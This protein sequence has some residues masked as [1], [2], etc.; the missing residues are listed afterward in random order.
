[1]PRLFTALEIPDAVAEALARYQCGLRGA[2]WIER[3]DLHVTLRFL[4]DVDEEVAEAVHAGLV[5]AR[6]RAPVDVTITGLDAFGGEALL[7]APDAG[8][9]LGRPPHDLDRAEPGG[10]EQHDLGAPDVLLGGVAVADQRLEAALV[11]MRNFN[12]DTGAHVPDSHTNPSG[13]NP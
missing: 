5:E 4:G 7:P 2:R 12:G 13:G 9:G 10:A 11:R 1:M 8:L 6:P 3:G